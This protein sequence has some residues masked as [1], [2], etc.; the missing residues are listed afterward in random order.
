[1]GVFEMKTVMN[2][3]TDPL[4][5]SLAQS[6]PNKQ[7]IQKILKQERLTPGEGEE[8]YQ[9]DLPLIGMLAT[10]VRKQKN[11]EDVFFNHNIHLEP[12]NICVY[13]CHFCSY[14]R[15]AHEEGAWSFSNQEMLQKV[16]AAAHKGI[17]EVHIVGGVHPDRDI[18]YYGSLIEQIHKNYPTI[19]IKAFT[20]VEID[21]M[22][23]K[24]RMPLDEGFRY[25]KDRGLG[26][27]PGG[28]AE[29]FNPQVRKKVCHEKS[30]GE[31]WLQIHKEAHK[32]GLH[33]NATMLYGHI[34]SLTDRIDHMQQLRQLQDR[35][36]GFNAFIPLKF[37]NANNRLSHIPEATLLE[38][39]KNYAVARIFLDNIPHIKAYWPMIGKD[40]A[41]LALSFGVDDL[42]GT[43]EDSTRIYTMAGSK[44][45][46][47]AMSTHDLI[48]LIHQTGLRAVERDTLYRPLQSF[49]PET[50]KNISES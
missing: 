12:T 45:T 3:L 15:K 8:L 40:A 37:K 43:I 31:D 16:E 28:G 47:P 17:T 23:K 22:C 39:M 50:T 36:K 25:L 20:A 5:S 33:S 29:I 32:Q 27:L 13:D 9:M 7:L 26:S 30:N 21:F 2:H 46:N 1:M 24:A 14:H 34:E 4:L 19:H 10:W 11:G 42:D 6:H 48:H 18:H 35:T 38:D 49:E 41:Q 44:E